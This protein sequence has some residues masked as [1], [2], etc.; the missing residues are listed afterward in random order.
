MNKS[1]IKKI[2]G[3]YYRAAQVMGVSPQA[4]GQWPDEL[5]QGHA[6]R[7]AGAALRMRLISEYPRFRRERG[8]K[9]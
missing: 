9:T 6:D 4:I 3:S 7:V 8:D 5:D 2:F 1:A